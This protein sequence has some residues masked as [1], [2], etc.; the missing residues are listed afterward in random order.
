V[1]PPFRALF[2]IDA[3]GYSK[4]PDIVLPELHTTIRWAVEQACERSGLGGTWQSVPFLQST[5][6]GVLAVLPYHAASLLI[7][8]F[9]DN[10]QQVLAE[11]AP[12]L[13]SRRLK[14]RLRAAV[15]VGLVDDEDP[16]T[17]GI[18]AATNDV[19]RLLDC[20]PLRGALRE[21]DPDITYAATIVSAQAY[22]LFVR[23]GHTNLEPSQFKRV[24][25]KVKQFEQAAYL[26]VPVPSCR[27]FDDD[28]ENQA[29]ESSEA[30]KH[31]SGEV[32]D[33]RVSIK[34]RNSQNAIGNHVGGN[35]TQ[36]RS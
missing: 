1:I 23:G 13:R 18:S 6:D 29:V 3:E 4:N 36:K 27:D 2:T 17:G 32:S 19:S 15:H 21:S 30:S 25:A 31:V 10:L 34:G 12:Q 11:I 9:T 20:E 33:F 35:I 5:G 22:D 28:K 14:L 7:Y 26:Y 8:P 24:Q 16:V